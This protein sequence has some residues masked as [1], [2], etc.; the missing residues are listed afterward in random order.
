M[1]PKPCRWRGERGEGEGE[2]ERERE[3]EGE[4]ERGKG[5]KRERERDVKCMYAEQAN[6]HMSYQSIDPASL[7][8][9]D[10]AI[11]HLPL[12]ID[13]VIDKFSLVDLASAVG[14]LALTMT[15]YE[16]VCVCECAFVDTMFV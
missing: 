12:S 8:L 1:A 10:F 14:Q 2:S 4:R 3:R 15:L 6:I 7:V 5:G 9:A 11:L 16:H 13:D